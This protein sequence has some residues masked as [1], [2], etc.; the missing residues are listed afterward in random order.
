VVPSRSCSSRCGNDRVIRSAPM[1]VRHSSEDEARSGVAGRL[2]PILFAT[3]AVFG[4][5][6]LA[7]ALALA[8]FLPGTSHSAVPLP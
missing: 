8:L 2:V 4:V 1:S 3:L 7:L 6:M 5:V